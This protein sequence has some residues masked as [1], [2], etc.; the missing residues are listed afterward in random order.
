MSDN[1]LQWL[2][3]IDL[4]ILYFFN[5]QLASSDLD[6]FWIVLTNLHK[7]EIVRWLI[8]PILLAGLLYIYRQ[9]AIR[10]YI[11]LALAILLADGIAYRIIKAVVSRPRPFS[12][13]EIATWLRKV[14]E[15]QGSSFPSNHAANMFASAVIL[16]WFFPRGRF[17]FYT[18][19]GLIAVSRIIL[20]VHYPSDVL[21]GALLGIIV[22]NVIKKI[23]I[24]YQSR[25]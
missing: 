10:L 6:P 25:K 5:V 7:V 19:A 12:N 21:A 24:L 2:S 22:G 17:Y 20:G 9:M 16:A 8:I 11:A 1:L 15:A 23:G 4:Q 18:F 14:G 13:I 3:Q